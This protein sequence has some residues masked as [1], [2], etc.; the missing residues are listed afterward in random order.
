MNCE[1]DS[2]QT[3]AV[4]YCDTSTNGGT[5]TMKRLSCADSRVSLCTAGLAT[6]FVSAGG[7][8]SDAHKNKRDNHEQHGNDD[9]HGYSPLR[10]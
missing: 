6:P 4:L 8:H 10:D 1:N 2:H 3:T 5:V 7:V 9:F